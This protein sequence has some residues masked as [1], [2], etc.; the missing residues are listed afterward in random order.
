MLRSDPIKA[1]PEDVP[2]GIS[3]HLWKTPESIPQKRKS[4][5]D[6][7]QILKMG[8]RRPLPRW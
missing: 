2:S 4:R 1:C 3:R 5:M 6:I 8:L 7:F